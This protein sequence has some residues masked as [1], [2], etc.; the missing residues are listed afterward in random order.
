MLFFHADHFGLISL[1]KTYHLSVSLMGCWLFSPLCIIVI[2][3]GSGIALMLVFG[4]LF[5]CLVWGFLVKIHWTSE[6][7]YALRSFIPNPPFYGL[8]FQSGKMQRKPFPVGNCS[9][10]G[11]GASSSLWGCKE[12]IRRADSSGGKDTAFGDKLHSS[13]VTLFFLHHK[14]DLYYFQPQHII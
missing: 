9:W 4:V 1:N 12:K 3:Y 5:V 13:A 14:P 8:T 2:L 11:G 6:L 7:E 10:G